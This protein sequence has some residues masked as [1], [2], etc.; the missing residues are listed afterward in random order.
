MLATASLPHLG[1]DRPQR[2]AITRHAPSV[3]P[4]RHVIRRRRMVAAAAACSVVCLATL[5]V[6]G[7]VTGPGGGP[8]SAAGTA[9]TRQPNSVVAHAGD[10][11]WSIAERHRGDVGVRRYVDA[12]IGLN[13]GTAIQ[14]GQAVRLP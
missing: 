8:A 9:T 13:G 4:A 12:L 14:A 7:V 1:G 10:S 3:R 11:L 5:G 6:H 2:A